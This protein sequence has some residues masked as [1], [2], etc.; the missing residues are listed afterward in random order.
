MLAIRTEHRCNTT[1]E[2]VNIVAMNEIKPND[3]II[4]L[5]NKNKQY[6]VAPLVEFTD[7]LGNWHITTLEDF[8]SQFKEI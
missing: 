4:Q 5:V 1:G 8:T 6:R 3:P 2:I 7:A